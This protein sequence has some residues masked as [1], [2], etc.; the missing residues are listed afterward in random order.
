MAD[1][2]WSSPRIH[3]CAR[4]ICSARTWPL[5]YYITII[6]RVWAQLHGHSCTQNEEVSL[7]KMGHAAAHARTSARCR[8][9]VWASEGFKLRS[10]PMSGLPF[11]P[12]LRRLAD[13]HGFPIICALLPGGS[14]KHRGCGLEPAARGRSQQKR[15]L[16]S[17][18]L[19]VPALS[20][21][22][23]WQ[24]TILL[25]VSTSTCCARR[26]GQRSV[27][28]LK[29]NMCAVDSRKRPAA[30]S[31]GSCEFLL[32]HARDCVQPLCAA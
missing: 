21:S 16:S 26:T 8:C 27:R 10:Q 28:A 23:C 6:V 20:C 32:L 29:H 17:S 14:A 19:G 12:G 11:S 13:E 22:R 15:V 7:A 1:C 9:G 25:V 18:S 4:P 30:W 3:F 24:A 31:R 5:P 2:G